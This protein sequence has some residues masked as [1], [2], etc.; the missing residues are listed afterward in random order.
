MPALT[1]VKLSGKIS[2]QNK[3]YAIKE[4]KLQAGLADITNAKIGLTGQVADLLNVKGVDI[5]VD[6]DVEN[7]QSFQRL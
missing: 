1:Q 4:M 6:L 7:S 2:D 3:T 5:I